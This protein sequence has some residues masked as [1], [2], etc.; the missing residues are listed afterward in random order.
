MGCDLAQGYFIGRPMPQEQINDWLDQREHLLEAQRLHSIEALNLKDVLYE[1]RFVR[2]TWLARK[3]LNV[4]ASYIALVDAE[5]QWIHAAQG[6]L[7]VRTNRS[8]AFC[9][10]TIMQDQTLVLNN[11]DQDPRFLLSPLIKK[12]PYIKFYAGCPI[13]APS[14]EKLGTMSITHNLPREF[15]TTDNELLTTL[16]EM[17]DSEIAANPM[18]DEDHLTGLLNQR[19]FKNRAETLLTLCSQRDHLLSMCY[20]DLDNFK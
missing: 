12:P 9:N 8:E 13:H 1:K 17:V 14:G 16:A 11:V 3:L 5:Y 2:L 7:P 19:G 15:S 18:L 4:D 6:D 10:L 20:F